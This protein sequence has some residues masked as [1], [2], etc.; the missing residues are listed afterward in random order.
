M[1]RHILVVIAAVSVIGSAAAFEQE[2]VLW[3]YGR[4]GKKIG[5]FE[6]TPLGS[7]LVS[8][9]DLIAALD[10]DTGDLIWVREDIKGCEPDQHNAV[11]CN[12]LGRRSTTFSAIANTNFGLF[13]Q[14]GLR[15][16]G[17]RA[18]VVDLATGSTIWDSVDSPFKKV[19]AFLYV[20]ELNQFMLA[21]KADDKRG[22]L[23]A[24]SSSDGALLWQRDINFVDRF[25]FIGV[26]DDARVLAYGKTV[27]RQRVLVSM[28]LTDGAED[29]RL[30]GTL[31]NDA[32]DRN[33]L[34]LRDTDATAILYVTK[35][36]PFRVRLDTGDV[37]WRVN[38]WDGDPPFGSA[39]MILD[40]E[41]LFVPNGKRIAALRVEDG[42]HVWRTAKKFR[43]EP[44]DVRMQS[45]GLLIRSRSFD[46]LDPRTGRSLWAKRTGK[47][48]LEAPAHVDEDTAYIAESKQFSTVDLATGGV[49]RL[50][51]YDFHGD[52]PTAVEETDGSFVVMS[53]QNLLRV[54][55]A[56]EIAYHVY[57]KAPGASFGMKMLVL[58]AAGAGG[59]LADSGSPVI[60]GVANT[61]SVL[62]GR[63][64]ATF[65]TPANYFM[66]TE[67]PVDGRK[68][69]S[70][71]RVDKAS[72]VE[73]GRLWLDERS[74]KYTI[75][76][77]TEIVYFQ[78]ADHELSALRFVPDS[79]DRGT[80]SSR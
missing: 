75:D 65:E 12:F 50:S 62:F 6:V 10:E 59:A 11:R 72:G 9:D 13:S 22:V 40:G 20:P 7:V 73:T 71:V 42:G 32:R 30:E 31:R 47:F 74:P 25:K 63:Y 43:A 41:M 17:D 3:K 1:F 44:I 79:T 77:L 60:I 23:L 54:N 19:E 34:V 55:R 56:G 24:V 35:D 33:A 69:F 16:P 70:L 18:A 29:W 49:T 80:S 4:V 37:L 51:K 76:H 46:L 14:G 36:G 61:D 48:P 53:R 8:T 21:G 58:A 27:R 52:A 38:A 2:S 45:R 26:P 78:N 5:H 67:M 57:L 66:Y 64:G 39:G 28:S 15:N 68:G